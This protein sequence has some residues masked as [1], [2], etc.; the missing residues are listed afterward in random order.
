MASWNIQK[1]Q[2][3]LSLHLRQ[4]GSGIFGLHRAGS[5]REL[6]FILSSEV[7]EGYEAEECDVDSNIDSVL[8]QQVVEFLKKFLSET[9]NFTYI[10]TYIQGRI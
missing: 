7:D 5:P 4:K 10:H 3:L 9:E 2:L 6:M 1:R 8:L